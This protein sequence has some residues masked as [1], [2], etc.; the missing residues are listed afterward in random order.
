MWQPSKMNH[1]RAKEGRGY[2]N[3]ALLWKPEGTGSLAVESLW[4]QRCHPPG[5]KI[6]GYIGGQCF[7]GSQ[8]LLPR[9]PT[10]TLFDG[11][12]VTVAVLTSTN[13]HFTLY[14]PSVL[15]EF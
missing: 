9:V 11:H 4:A 1:V 13:S 8:R 2:P 6:Q 5:P 10:F 12:I 15:N 7:S 3:K 14:N